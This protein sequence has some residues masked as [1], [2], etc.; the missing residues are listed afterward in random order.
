MSVVVRT[1]RA[2]NPNVTAAATNWA[3]VAG[4]GGTASG[5]RNTGDGYDGGAGFY[6]V[7]WTVATTALSGGFTYTQTGLSASTQYT[8][9]IYVR[10]SKA[11]TVFLKAQYQNSSSTNVGAATNGTAVAL[12]ANEWARITVTATSG[13]AVDRV[14]LTAAAT[15][16]G[17]NWA[18]GDT[19]D[20]DCIQIE[21]GATATDFFDGSYANGGGQAYAWTG[22]ADASTSTATAYN[23]TLTLVAKTD[24]PTDRVE[25]TIADLYPAEATVTV[26]RTVDGFRRPVREGENLVV[27]GTDAVVDYEAPLGRVITY[28]LEITAGLALG[29]PGASG[30][31]TLTPAGSYGWIQDPLD[32]ASA[33][34]LYGDVGPNGESALTDQSVHNLA[35][36]A[37]VSLIP[38]MGSSEPVA[39]IG[40][41]MVASKIPF[42]I[43]TDAAEHTTNL[44]DLL[45][46]APLVLI[47]TLPTWGTALPALCYC[48]PPEPTED[49]INAPYGGTL[50][51]WSFETGLVAPPRMKLVVPIWTYGDVQAL[52][53]TYQQA[54]TALSGKTYLAVRISPPNGL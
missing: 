3:A 12:V 4:T 40:Q 52:W 36:A 10:S 31:V 51:S 45:M 14:V 15:T 19:F 38:I 29:G 39:L 30:T 33:I 49:P 53:T 37:D 24:A 47:R 21:L 16:G 2:T 18:N 7:S 22:T 5:A 41:R 54:Q 34:K 32:P 25:I 6:R 43:L 1:N 27:I 8:H 44:R 28:E 48:A 13:A 23:P 17:A 35:Y 26:Y 42:N 46:Q 9:A 20:G 11:Q 50:T